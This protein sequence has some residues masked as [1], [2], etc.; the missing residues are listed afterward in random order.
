M[1]EM[2]YIMVYF[3]SVHGYR[4]RDW[5]MNSGGHVDTLSGT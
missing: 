3:G 1:G 4:E 5:P 2:K